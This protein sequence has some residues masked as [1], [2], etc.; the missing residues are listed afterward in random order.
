VTRDKGAAVNVFINGHFLLSEFRSSDKDLLVVHLNDRDIYDRTLRIPFP[1]AEP[2][3][4]SQPCD[5]I[6]KAPGTS[7][8]WRRWPLDN[9]SSLR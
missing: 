2:Q 9:R 6:L 1:D 5:S 3:P 7:G 4:S 8:R